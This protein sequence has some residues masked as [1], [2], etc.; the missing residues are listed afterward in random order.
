VANVSS[1]VTRGIRVDVQSEHLEDRSEPESDQWFFAYHIRISNESAETVRLV[2][3]R[4]II[5]DAQGRV[6]EV[7]GM[8]VVG[9]QPVLRPGES[10]EYTSGCPLGTP[11][12]AMQGT[13]RMV[14]EEGDEF[15]AEIAPFGLHESAELH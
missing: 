5:T 11:F 14:T 8:G 3:R 9:Q 2:S 4:W 6:Q 7:R 12:G 15:D 1:A 10:F 13:Y